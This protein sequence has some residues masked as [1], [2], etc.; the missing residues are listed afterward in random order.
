MT[1]APCAVPIGSRIH[2]Q[3]VGPRDG[4]QSEPWPVPTS[5]KI[6]LIN[7]LVRTGIKQIE[8]TSFTSPR[9]TPA[10]ADAEAVVRGLQ[11]EP[12]VRYAAL[13]PN[14][15][16]AERAAAADI[17]HWNMV[18]S[19]SEDHNRRNL[20]MSRDESMRVL[21]EV[22]RLAHEAKCSTNLSL[23]CAFDG[24]AVRAGE[25]GNLFHLVD[26]FRDMGVSV[27]TL[28][29]T[30]GLAAP[31]RVGE[32]VGALRE[33]WP[34]V[35]LA[36]HFHDTRGG[37]LA[38]VLAALQHGVDRYDSSIGGLGGCPAMPG[39]GGNVRTENVVRVLGEM[40]YETGIDLNALV[41]CAAALPSLLRHD[42]PLLR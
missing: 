15:R 26:Y 12:G 25:A 42:F 8:V 27:F 6:Q 38:N 31:T 5:Q 41:A 9:A 37:G 30:S 34:D 14:V 33:R 19:V 21:A 3:E 18:M 40:G 11:R 22:V 32:V 1:A 29:D 23:S 7:R 35:S 24:D 17:D 39:A 2:I 20:R 4:L 10:L 13:V 36:G 28:C 16:G